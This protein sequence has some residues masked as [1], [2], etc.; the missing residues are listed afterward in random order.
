[1]S[2]NKLSSL[3]GGGQLDD[4]SL[5]TF[6]DISYNEFTQ[7]P[8]EIS[9]LISLEKLYVNNNC[10]KKLPVEL[11]KLPNLQILNVANNKLKYLPETIGNL[12]NLSIL[13][14]SRNKSLTKL[15][16]S[17]GQANKLVDIKTD[18]CNN[19]TYPPK[20]ILQGGAIA[21]VAFLAQEWG[22]DNK[23]RDVFLDEQMNQ[24]SD[25]INKRLTENTR[26]NNYQAT[27]TQLEKTKEQRQNAL[28]ELEKNIREQQESEL[29]LQSIS[30]RQKKK[31]L[32][33]LILQQSH[34]EL[35]IE[36]IQQEKELN[37]ARFLD[38]INEAEKNADNVIEKFLI[39]NEA[40]R[41]IQAEL[42]ER[43]KE[44]QL[45]L[46]SKCHEDQSSVRTKETLL[47]M[48]KLLKEELLTEKKIEEYTK[49]RECN[50]H[51][52]LSLELRNNDYLAS[53]IKDQ[54]RNRENLLD[55]LRKDQVLQKAALTALLERSDARS[56]SI[57]QQVNLIESQLVALTN[58]EL[59]RKKLEI[60]QQIN[61]I[62]EKRVILSGILVNLL[63]KQEKRREQLLETINQIESRKNDEARRNSLFWLMQYQS[64]MDSRPQ[65]LLEGLDPM[66]VRHVAIAGVLHCLPFLASLS[67]L[68]PNVDDYQ[69]EQ[70]GI[71]NK[72]DRNAILLAIENYLAERKIVEPSA[73]ELDEA[74]TEEPSTSNANYSNKNVNATECVICLDCQ[75]EVIFLPCGHFCCCAS[76]S[77]K[78]TTECPMCRGSIQRK[79]QVYKIN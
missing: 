67:T 60:N 41:H 76:C 19:I 59:E 11:A 14:I 75:S 21:I 71:H 7:L 37:R 43:E 70:L 23:A 56:W 31:L 45:Q 69:L 24:L 74:L 39:N 44:E 13:D 10:I 52:L 36:R 33:D 35:E 9:F 51:S 18:E 64:L 16:Q 30:Q 32:E 6:L 3:S 77:N 28:L 79:I 65:G 55:L 5:L 34:L 40:E 73:P 54:K 63:D 62:A 2:K 26:N 72:D 50:A 53:T 61:D 58:I 49:F 22:I 66:L 8:P 42:I 27:L 46:L 1:M 17:L 4:L 15:P 25:D 29:E 48:E 12:K 57:V 78:V 38:F 20:Y 47:A 68:L